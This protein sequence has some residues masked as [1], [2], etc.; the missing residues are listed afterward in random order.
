VATRLDGAQ[1]A[2]EI[3][4]EVA[5]EVEGLRHR[6][7]FRP[8]LAVV[9]VGAHPASEI[10][11]RN[12]ARACKEAGI[13]SE[14][15]R[16]D[17]GIGAA[18]LRDLVES[19]N[20]NH[21]IDG[22]LIQL[23]LPDGFD[24]SAA[25]TMIDPA[26]DVDGFHPENVGRLVRNEPGLVPCTPA[27]VLRLLHR[28]SIP[29]KGQRA[30]VIGRSNIVGKPTA[31]LLMHE[32]ATVTICHSRTRDLAKVAAEADILIA[33]V[34]KAAIVTEEFVRPGAAVIDVG[35]HRLTSA[36]EVESIFANVPAKLEAFRN[37]GAVLVGDVHP[38]VEAVAG[39]LSPVP[40]GVGPLTVAMLLANTVRAARMRRLQGVAA[41][42]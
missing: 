35:I 23:P 13:G 21:E 31:M 12:K 24:D 10:Y 16:P 18:G 14:V 17:P 15:L 5:I 11:V 9:L 4:Q 19:L 28:N 39:A 3:R 41:S 40:G 25:T 37:R 26:K 42:A 36:E 2:K 7:G 22:I 30:V 33:A 32:H 29:I 20:R 1:L 6:H 27:G 8:T 34:G 38:G